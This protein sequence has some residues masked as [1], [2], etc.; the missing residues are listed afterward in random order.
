LRSSRKLQESSRKHCSIAVLI[1]SLFPRE[2]VRVRAGSR[3]KFRNP[4][5]SSSPLDQ[6]GEA[7]SFSTK[8]TDLIN[9]EEVPR[10]RFGAAAR[11]E[12][13]EYPLCIFPLVDHDDE[14]GVQIYQVRLEEEQS[15]A[16]EDASAIEP[17]TT[18]AMAEAKIAN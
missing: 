12:E 11:R 13:G 3:A 4:S 10:Q 16:L 9:R 8:P 6:R 15:T 5:P 1:A 2:R 7:T 14:N 18:K 17:A